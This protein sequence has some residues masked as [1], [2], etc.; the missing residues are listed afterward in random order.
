MQISHYVEMIAP[1][2]TTHVRHAR[3]DA[4]TTET[5][6][7]LTLTLEPGIGWR[8]HRAGQFVKVGVEVDGRILTRTYSIS[9]APERG[10]GRF[11]ITVKAIP[12]GRVSN[13]LHRMKRGAYVTIGLPQGEFVMNGET[14]ALFVT[15]G[16]GVTPVMSMLRSLEARG[17]DADVVHLHYARTSADAI[18]GG[19]LARMATRLSGYRHVLVETDRGGRLFDRETLAAHVPDVATRSTWACGPEPLL[20]A[21]QSLVKHDVHVERF[22]ANLRA[23]NGTTGGRVRFGR[24]KREVDALPGAPLLD[25]A[26]RA[27]VDAPHGCRIGICHSCDATLVSGAVCDLRSGARIDEPGARFQPCVCAASGDVEIDL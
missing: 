18:F 1:L 14:R 5:A 16:S 7:A 26:Q 24:S 3:V 25:V 13:A 19:E 17:A 27:N 2:W 9:S 11:T 4:V 6:D 15:G 22:R 23:P 10:D 8:T 20:D 21:V 12:N